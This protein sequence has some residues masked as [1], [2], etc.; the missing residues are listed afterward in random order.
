MC[1]FWDTAD[2]AD[3]LICSFIYLGHK[4][5]KGGILS[6]CLCVHTALTTKAAAA[7]PT[8]QGKPS[9]NCV[10]YRG[11]CVKV[12]YVGCLQVKN[13]TSSQK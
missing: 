5:Q 10:V 8:G 4:K 11:S 2:A 1:R 6:C 13:L 12:R 9:V 7:P 3:L